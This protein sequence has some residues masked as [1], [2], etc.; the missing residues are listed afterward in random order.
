[1]TPTEEAKAIITA[2]FILYLIDSLLD[3][4]ERFRGTTIR[5]KQL[6]LSKTRQ[7]QHYKYVE[8]SNKVW[9]NV[10]EQYKENKYHVVIF[11]AVESLAFAEEEIM[12]K[13]FGEHFL[14]VVGNFTLKI[15]YDG[16]DKELL[17]ES[18]EICKALKKSLSKVTFDNKEDL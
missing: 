11:D 10:V 6:L 14:T 18:R 3:D 4:K 1:M 9:T 8:M 12:V 13:M 5:L 2:S 17:R 7:A 15:T 16:V